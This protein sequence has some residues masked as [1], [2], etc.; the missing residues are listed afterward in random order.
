[1]ANLEVLSR[2]RHDGVVYEIGSFI[3]DIGEKAK[4]ELIAVGAVKDL[5]ADEQTVESQAKQD[6]STAKDQVDGIAGT[7]ASNVAKD[8]KDNEQL[9]ATPAKP[10]S[11]PAP[12]GP[13]AEE[14]A[15]TAASQN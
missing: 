4:A 6:F 7:V 13:S 3:K 14:I 10:T 8:L 15:A 2:I 5:E 11:P 12:N 9:A 1:M